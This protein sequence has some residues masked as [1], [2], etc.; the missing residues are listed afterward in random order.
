MF[1]S[2]RRHD[3]EHKEEELRRLKLQIHELMYWCSADSPEIGFAMLHL[4]GKRND[5][6]VFRDKLR[7]GLF[8]FEAFKKAVK[9]YCIE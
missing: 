2:K 6:S 4:Q 3:L 9:E 7:K 5:T 1:K 8:T